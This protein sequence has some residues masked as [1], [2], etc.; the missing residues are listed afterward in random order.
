MNTANEH[1]TNS[2]KPS[3]EHH[4]AFSTFTICHQLYIIWTKITISVT[5]TC[6]LCGFLFCFFFPY[7]RRECLKLCVIFVEITIALVTEHLSHSDKR[8]TTCM[9]NKREKIKCKAATALD[10]DTNSNDAFNSRQSL[11]RRSVS[12]RMKRTFCC[13]AWVN[14]LFT[15]RG[16]HFAS[17]FSDQTRDYSGV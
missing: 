8:K 3:D 10:D 7:R 9:N 4:I 1:Q 2:K 11:M 17:Y 12:R 14:V 15:F 5:V 13:V 16:E 6:C